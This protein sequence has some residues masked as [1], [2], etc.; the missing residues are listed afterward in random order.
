MNQDFPSDRSCENVRSNQPDQNQVTQRNSAAQFNIPENSQPQN[1]YYHNG[2]MPNYNSGA[3]TTNIPNRIKPIQR[4]GVPT[5]VFILSIIFS[6]LIGGFLG[7]RIAKLS[8]PTPAVIKP[9]APL[10]SAE[11]TETIS[12]SP[13]QSSGA[14]LTAPATE[15]APMIIRITETQG[16]IE[17]GNNGSESSTSIQTEIEIISTP[18]AFDSMETATIEAA[19]D[20]GTTLLESPSLDAPIYKTLLNGTVVELTGT[21]VV[22]K[23]S[24]FVKAR[25]TDGLEG[26][27]LEFSIT[28]Q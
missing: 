7:F 21:R 1:T 6:L 9:M 28:K 20:I 18:T 26:W 19:G 12:S 23:G 2:Y 4:H 3:P 11:E 5:L 8:E 17:I 22:V 27:I 24:P 15:A 25:T 16:S 14:N 13:T 10:I